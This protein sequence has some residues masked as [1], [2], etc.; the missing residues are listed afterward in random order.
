MRFLPALLL[1]SMAPAAAAQ[2]VLTLDPGSVV[3]GVGETATVRVSRGPFLTGGSRLPALKFASANA[4]IIQVEG[5]L[6]DPHWTGRM[7]IT[8]LRPGKGRALVQGYDPSTVHVAVTVVCRDEPPIHAAEPRQTTKI[9]QP[10]TLR[11]ETPIAGR[12]TFTWYHGLAGDLSAPIAASGPEIPFA[13]S[14]PGPHHAWVLATT[15]CSSTT[16]QFE[17][18]AVAP[19]RRSARQ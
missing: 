7:R 15:P 13:T 11:A 17:I 14:D 12:T 5:S 9:G 2:T 4:S 16:A 1:I 3:V 8:G 10:V 18:E 19:R 6:T